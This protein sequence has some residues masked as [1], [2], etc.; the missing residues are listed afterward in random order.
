MMSIWFLAL[1]PVSVVTSI[2][3]GMERMKRDQLFTTFFSKRTRGASNETNSCQ[4][5][6]EKRSFFIQCE[7]MLWNWETGEVH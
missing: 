5:Q 6:S 7:A 2:A 4:V 3:S 1:L